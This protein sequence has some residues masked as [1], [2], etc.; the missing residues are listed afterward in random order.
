MARYARARGVGD[1]VEETE[2]TS[3]RTNLEYSHALAPNLSPWMAATSDYHA[4]RAAVLMRELK[5][6]GNAVGA[7]TPKYFWAAAFLREYVA[8]L[9]RHAILNISMVIVSSVPLLFLVLSRTFS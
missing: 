2:S 5:I 3:T 8:V 6:S 4:F 9:R 7:K 1:V